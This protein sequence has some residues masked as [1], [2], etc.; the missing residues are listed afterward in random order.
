MDQP[1]SYE[2]VSEHRALLILTLDA[3]REE[4]IRRGDAAQTVSEITEVLEAVKVRK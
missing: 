1:L 4:L 2:T 3:V